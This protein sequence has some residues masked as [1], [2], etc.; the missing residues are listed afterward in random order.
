MILLTLEDAKLLLYALA[1]VTPSGGGS[2]QN[3]LLVKLL[4]DQGM[5]YD[6]LDMARVLELQM[7]AC[8]EVES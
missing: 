7:V 3:E 4:D 8:S 6:Q 5:V 2:P 1:A